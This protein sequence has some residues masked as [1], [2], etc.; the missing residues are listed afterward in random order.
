M[1]IVALL[2]GLLIGLTPT[3]IEY[4]AEA[5]KPTI[6]ATTTV[7]KTFNA[8]I[9][10][11]AKKYGQ[12]ETL[13]R[14]IISCESKQYGSEGA[15]KNYTK[16]GEWWS[17]DWGWWQINDYYNEAPAL[18]RGYD[19]FDKW[20]NLEFGFIMLKEQGTGPWSA[21]KACWSKT[22]PSA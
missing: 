22:I 3:K 9:A 11:L 19:I 4:S 2:T 17:T 7:P 14:A 15:H 13:A 5:A 6:E 8:E 12:S 20:Q 16:A 18:R 10:R 1:W 21:S